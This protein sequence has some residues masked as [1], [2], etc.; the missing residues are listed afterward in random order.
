MNRSSVYTGI[1]FA[2]LLLC[3]IFSGTAVFAADNG[4]QITKH[5][6]ENNVYVTRVYIGPEITHIDEDSFLNLHKLW[7]IQV[8]EGNP[9]YSTYAN[10]LYNKDKTRLLCFPFGLS[11]T[12]LPD[13]VTQVSPYALKGKCDH[14]KKAIENAVKKNQGE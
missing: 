6:Y 1:L 2:V 9:Y 13:T 5:T 8:D 14:V 12:M 11:K 10:C 7:L 3:L 4:T